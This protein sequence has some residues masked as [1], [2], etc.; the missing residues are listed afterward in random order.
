MHELKQ[1]GL[2]IIQ[3][4]IIYAIAM[5]LCSVGLNMDL[6]PEVASAAPVDEVTATESTESAEMTESIEPAKWES[7]AIGSALSYKELPAAGAEDDPNVSILRYFGSTDY[8]KETNV[9]TE[10]YSNSTMDERSHANAFLDYFRTGFVSYA[11]GSGSEELY[12]A[13]TDSNLTTLRM[14]ASYRVIPTKEQ[15]QCIED[16]R[17]IN[18]SVDNSEIKTGNY[19][20]LI[21]ES[22]KRAGEYDIIV[23]K[24]QMDGK[25]R[26]VLQDLNV[27]SLVELTLDAGSGAA[28]GSDIE[29]SINEEQTIETAA[30][31]EFTAIEDTPAGKDPDSE[32]N[33]DI[34]SLIIGISSKVFFVSLAGLV[35]YIVYLRGGSET[36]ER[37]LGLVRRLIPINI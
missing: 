35:G 33:S 28:A 37:I 30:S 2:Y 15:T 27:V 13:A 23:A 3:Q 14:I 22:S 4:I 21:H 9:S 31:T 25:V 10:K 36:K 11:K 32:D 24:A 7:D 34:N 8:V 16:G 26:F 20:I 29:T 1:K 12:K 17:E 19:Y 18:V 5:M 6:S